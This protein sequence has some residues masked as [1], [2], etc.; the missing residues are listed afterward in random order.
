MIFQVLPSEI[1]QLRRVFQKTYCRVATSVDYTAHGPRP[2]A[3]VY[4]DIPTAVRQSAKAQG[5]EAT[6]RFDLVGPRF[7]SQSV[8]RKASAPYVSRPLL[9]KSLV[10]ILGLDLTLWLPGKA[11]SG[12]LSG[13]STLSV[14]L[15]PTRS[16][17]ATPL[18]PPPNIVPLRPPHMALGALPVVFILRLVV[19]LGQ[20]F[21]A[22]ICCPLLQGI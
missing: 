22:Q 2:M 15:M 9:F 10:S 3:M 4:D 19:L 7:F 14:G 18:T 17:N 11:Q 13:Q 1:Q 6:L 21:A 16:T 12:L 20:A 8:L 5:A